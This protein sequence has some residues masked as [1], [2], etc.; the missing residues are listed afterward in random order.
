MNVWKIYCPSALLCYFIWFFWASVLATDGG[1]ER[2]PGL[3]W[4]TPCNASHT[5]VGL[6]TTHS[7]WVVLQGTERGNAQPVEVLQWWAMWGRGLEDDVPQPPAKSNLLW[8]SSGWDSSLPHWG[9][10]SILIGD[11]RSCKQQ[12]SQKEKGWHAEG[13]KCFPELMN[14]IWFCSHIYSFL[15]I[16]FLYALCHM[17]VTKY[18][19]L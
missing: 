2:A 18:P 4:G 15:N 9:T 16:T 19:L 13:H 5:A 14:I 11:V 17:H 10:G 8:W 12:C 3:F 1:I 7:E 6:L